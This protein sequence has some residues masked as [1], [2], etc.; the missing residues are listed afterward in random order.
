MMMRRN[1]WFGLL[2]LAISLV[3]PLRVQAQSGG[4]A[5]DW[6]WEIQA[7]DGIVITIY[8]PQPE[9]LTGNLL[10]ARAA[11]SITTPRRSEPIFGTVWFSAR[12]DADRDA[13][14]AQLHSIA[15]TNVRWPEV[16]PEQAKE[17]TSIVEGSL[18]ETG[19]S[20]SLD[21]LTASLATAERER[22]S[23]EGLKSEPPK[24]VFADRRAVLLL[25]DG[26]PQVRPIE[27]TSLD[28]AVNTPFAVVK[29]R[30]TQTWYLSGGKI[31][32]SA[33]DPL[34]PWLPNARPPAAVTQ[35]VPR[36]TSSTP[37][38]STPARVVVATEPTEL[39]A[40]DGAPDW[41]AVAGGKLL[42]AANTES[43]WLRDVATQSQYLLV[44]G[45]WFTSTTREGPWTFVRPDQLPAAF[46]EIAP[47]S[48]IGRVRVA[49]AGTP[50]AEEA[51][52]DMA[53][54]Q[55][56]TI[57]R[58]EAKLE[59]RYDGEPQ[60]KPIEGTGVEYAVNTQTQVLRINGKYYAV[61][62]AVWFAADRATG[63]WVVADSVPKQEIDRIPPSAPVYNVTN[64][65]IF[66]STPEVVYVGYY[67]GYTWAFPWYG[68]PV[69]GTGW[70]YPP[71]FGAVYYPRPVTYGMHISYNPWTGWGFGFTWSAGFMTVGIGFHP[72][73]PHYGG[74]YPAYGYRPPYYRPYPPPGYRPLPPGGVYPGGRPRPT[75]YGNNVYNNVGNRDRV[76]R[77]GTVPAT[78]PAVPGAGARPATP[79]TR[80]TTPAARPTQRP[81]NVF[82][83]PNGD[84]FRQNPSGDWDRRGSSGW[85]KP[86]QTPGTLSRDARAR[87][88][89]ASRAATRGGARAGGRRP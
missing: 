53:V 81:N 2:S 54:P 22:K 15:V 68:V 77:P 70:Y 1:W 31:W 33:T 23:L 87:N 45:R 49:V 72:W 62:Q 25:Y 12:V 5:P 9:K 83:S 17:F 85:T 39:I 14:L 37:T 71:Y 63:P 50:E 67:P 56:A 82:S 89:G 73:G 61:D 26:A 24:L 57:R 47:D 16:T 78:R 13:S 80:P 29:D 55:T 4:A 51:L 42:Y 34:G 66:G 10:T 28:Q 74:W 64:V 20:T 41:K 43:V 44:S 65:E 79:T 3:G 48:D 30:G 21:R 6:P 58:S 75:P 60:F 59:V 84:V 69:Y 88:S 35:V 8:Q 27:G 86:S 18:P 40:T 11:M 76:A 38:P 19:F 7:R 32:Y 36:D 46:A 52:L